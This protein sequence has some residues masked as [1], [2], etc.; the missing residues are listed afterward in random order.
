MTFVINAIN[1]SRQTI[2]SAL[3][4][5]RIS[6]VRKESTGISRA[7]QSP[8]VC[9]ARCPLPRVAHAP[10]QP[11]ARPSAPKHSAADLYCEDFAGSFPIP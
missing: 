8:K 11:A 6:T 9:C 3:R 7:A 5:A 10:L 4:S 2:L 1:N